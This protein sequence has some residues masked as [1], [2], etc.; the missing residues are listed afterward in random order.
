MGQL[1]NIY[2]DE[3][4]HLEH[5]GEIAQTRND[6]KAELI[7]KFS[8]DLVPNDLTASKKLILELISSINN[9]N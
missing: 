4:C 9:D 1:Y 5:D 8:V 2:C 7:T 3:S 6:A